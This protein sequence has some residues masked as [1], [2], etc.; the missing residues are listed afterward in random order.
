MILQDVE[1]GEI[2]KGIIEKVKP[3]ELEKL[4]G[5]K[6]F[7]FDWSREIDADVYKI[8]V[9]HRKEIL[10]LISLVD[11]SKE[12][13]IHINLIESNKLHRGRDKKIKNIPGSLISYACK[14]AFQKGYDGFVSLIPKT[15]LIDYYKS[16][17][18]VQ[19]GAH[20]AVFL[21][22]SRLLILK[23]IGDEEV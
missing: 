14:V 1:T 2:C 6:D 18:F 9:R 5:N 11:I 8:T 10:G 20:M 4:K 22:A 12:L 7:T 15:E 17:G 13:R 19:V 16:Y 23:Y 3:A 21:E